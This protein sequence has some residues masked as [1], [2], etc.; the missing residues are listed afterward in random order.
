[1]P[2]FGAGS[3]FVQLISNENE[4]QKVYKDALQSYKNYYQ[5]GGVDST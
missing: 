2:V 1:M 5:S 3:F 4:L